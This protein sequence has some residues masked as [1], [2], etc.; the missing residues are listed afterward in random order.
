MSDDGFYQL[1]SQNERTESFKEAFPGSIINM[2]FR[3]DDNSSYA[4]S[5]EVKPDDIF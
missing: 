1:D 5:G 2:Q 4:L 3:T